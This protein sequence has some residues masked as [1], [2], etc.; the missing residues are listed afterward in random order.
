MSLKRSHSPSPSPP[1]HFTSS[2][3]N[4]RKSTFIAIFSPTL[5]GADLRRIPAFKR[6][7]HKILA[8]RKL[9][10]QR[11]LGG[12][13]KQL[14]VTNSDD[15]GEKYAGKHLERVLNELRVEGSV[16]VGR[17]YGGVLLGPVRFEHIRNVAREAVGL[18]LGSVG[19]GAD[20]DEVGGGKRT[21]V[22]DAVS[23]N[24]EGKVETMDEVMAKRVQES[25]EKEKLLQD[26][27]ERDKSIVSLRKLL[28]TKDKK[29]EESKEGE[30]ASSPI[31]SQARPP[32]DY[33]KMPLARLRQLEKARDAT[34]GF[35][36]K[37]IDA[38]EAK[39][40][41]AVG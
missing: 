20:G 5:S 35:I 17:W 41:K 8:T 4:D 32:I 23:G 21:K 29:D 6:A 9:S 7:D 36:L 25:I 15:D 34:I 38:A 1:N 39:E 16:V 22:E 14:H 24:E 12:Q 30:G 27:E 18:W 11:T 2:P 10:S 40:K 31:S 33:E 37:Q 19:R 26:L 3:I 13:G 28:A